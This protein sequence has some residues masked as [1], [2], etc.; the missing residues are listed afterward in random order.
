MTNENGDKAKPPRARRAAHPR[1]LVGIGAAAPEPQALY[2]LAAELSPG[3]TYVVCLSYQE[4]LE[5]SDVLAELSQ[6]ASLPVVLASPGPVKPDRIYLVPAMKVATLERGHFKLAGAPEAMGE[7]GR[8]DSLLV[9]IA[10]EAREHAVG[11]V[12]RGTNGDGTLAIGALKE[13]GGLALVESPEHEDAALAMQAGPASI[14]DFLLT[15]REIGS[16]IAEYAKK[17]EGSAQGRRSRR[18]PASR[19]R[20]SSPSCCANT[21]RRWRSF[22]TSRSSRPTSTDGRWPLPGSAASQRRSPRT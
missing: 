6:A 19:S 11:A 21:W 13:H 17:L 22:R 2:D 12:L 15:P 16:H 8:I 7:R 5:D 14:A 20:A 3:A 10:E 18:K 4:A 1:L 9:S